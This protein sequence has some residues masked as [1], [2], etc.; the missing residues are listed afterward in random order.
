MKSVFAIM[1][2]MLLL[3]GCD[4]SRRDV[5]PNPKTTPV[6]NCLK[7]GG[8]DPNDSRLDTSTIMS[9][10]WVTCKDGIVI[11]KWADGRV[12]VL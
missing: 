5:Q 2:A 3:V 8:A 12:D 9:S 4:D 11:R 6:P 1:C 7:H 10:L